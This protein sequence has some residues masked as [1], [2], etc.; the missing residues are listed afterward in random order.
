[1]GLM[2]VRVGSPE[3]CKV[4]KTEAD[5]VG[6]AAEVALMV[7]EFELPVAVPPPLEALAPAC[8]YVNVAVEG[9]ETMVKV[10][11]KLESETLAMVTLTPAKKPCAV[12]VVMV[13]REPVVIV[14]VDAPEVAVP[15]LLVALAPV[16][17]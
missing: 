6:S 1:M 9:T 17:A 13:T 2:A 8:E 14:A 16:C 4:T 12:V 3:V 11:L 15:P 10:P 7:T 5:L